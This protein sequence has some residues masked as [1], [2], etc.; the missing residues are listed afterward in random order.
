MLNSNGRKYVALAS[1]CFKT[2]KHSRIE[3]TIGSMTRKTLLEEWAL[4]G[5]ISGMQWKVFRYGNA[6]S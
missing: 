1:D 3:A 2:Q 4:L 5:E 6:Q